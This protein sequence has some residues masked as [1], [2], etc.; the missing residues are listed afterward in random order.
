M[1]TTSRFSRLVFLLFTFR[2]IYLIVNR[3]LEFSM[4]VSSLFHMMRYFSEKIIN[5]RKRLVQKYIYGCIA[6]Y[7]LYFTFYVVGM[8]REVDYLCIY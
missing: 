8:Y 7:L 2:D 4:L 3:T 5:V 6:A 1:L